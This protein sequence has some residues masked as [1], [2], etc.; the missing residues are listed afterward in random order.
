MLKARKTGVCTLEEES[1]WDPYSKEHLKLWEVRGL[2]WGWDRLLCNAGANLIPVLTKG[3]RE[4]WSET[5][6]S[7]NKKTILDISQIHNWV[8]LT[9][10][11]VV[12][13]FWKRGF[14]KKIWPK[15]ETWQWNE[16]WPS[17]EGSDW[18]H[19]FQRLFLWCHFSCISWI[20]I[21][22]TA[23]RKINVFFLS[24]LKIIKIPR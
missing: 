13:E 11:K 2:P 7:L 9:R 5:D 21:V 18:K 20:D 19:I 23:Q 14:W 1:I 4:N 24:I 22:N 16:N 17:R 8:M 6:V 15:I 3:T 10:C 12:R